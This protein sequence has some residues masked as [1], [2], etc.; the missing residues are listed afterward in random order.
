MLDLSSHLTGT[1]IEARIVELQQ[2]HIALQEQLKQSQNSL[3]SHINDAALRV[4]DIL[5]LIDMTQSKPTSNQEA[6]PSTTS[7]VIKKIEKRLIDI[8]L[9]WQVKEID[10]TEGRVETGNI[11][12]LETRQV[13]DEKTEGS[14]VEVC[15]K[16]YQRENKTIRPTDVITARVRNLRIN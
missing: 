12:V 8:L 13:F 14:I 15:R 16:G 11:R 4:I 10:V 6:S 7:P 1:I 2:S 5:D 9:R 3:E